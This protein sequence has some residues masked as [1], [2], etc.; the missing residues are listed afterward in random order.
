MALAGMTGRAL[1]AASI[2]ELMA[3]A[4]EVF[5]AG[6]VSLPSLKIRTEGRDKGIYKAASPRLL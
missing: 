4:I 1:S 6:P 2:D 3:R 5:V